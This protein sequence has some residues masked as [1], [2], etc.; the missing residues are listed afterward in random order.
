MLIVVTHFPHS[1]KSVPGLLLPEDLDRRVLGADDKQEMLHLGVDTLEFVTVLGHLLHQRS[2]VQL[3]VG[4]VVL[5][6]DVQQQLLAPVRQHQV[7]VGTLHLRIRAMVKQ[8]SDRTA[9]DHLPV[10]RGL[11][12]LHTKAQR[13][14]N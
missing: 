2:K 1:V 3:R 7:G 10:L 5:A 11:G 9:A 8:R 6:L 4:A 13:N 12:G 14:E